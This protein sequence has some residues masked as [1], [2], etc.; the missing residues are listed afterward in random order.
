VLA[1]EA[2]DERIET[3][4]PHELHSHPLLFP[5]G[6]RLPA[7]GFKLILSAA[8]M[9]DSH[10]WSRYAFPTLAQLL[11]GGQSQLRWAA[12]AEGVDIPVSG[13]SIGVNKDPMFTS[14]RGQP[15]RICAA[16]TNN[17]TVDLEWV[18]PH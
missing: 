13:G 12:E 16:V 9:S 1:I 17:R 5:K 7:H 14:L 3:G 6:A 2:A 18:T 11:I 10:L 4:R 15:G 8:T